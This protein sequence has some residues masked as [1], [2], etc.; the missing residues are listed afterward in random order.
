[1]SNGAFGFD[2]TTTEGNDFKYLVVN[3]VEDAIQSDIFF[4]D[5]TVG[6]WPD[7][8][9]F[10]EVTVT[11]KTGQTT[12]GR[13][14]L[15]KDDG[16]EESKKKKISSIQ[17]VVKNFATK[18]LGENAKLGGNDLKDFFEKA[19]IAIKAKPGWDKINLTAMFIHDKAGFTKLRAF[20]PIVELSSTPDKVAKLKHSNFEIDAF[21]KKQTPSAEGNGFTSSTPT[22]SADIF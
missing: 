19:V 16:T 7:G 1:M 8:A 5:F 17:A 14:S 10:L 22:T 12:T 15:G 11:N 21:V 6:A 18:V 9:T 2:E 3:G 13:Y 4:K 20:S